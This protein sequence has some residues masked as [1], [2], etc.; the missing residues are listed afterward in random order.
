MGAYSMDSITRYKNFY[1][2]IK[3]RN[4]KYPFAIFNTDE[5]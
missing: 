5:N 4:G 1:A 2:V 3:K